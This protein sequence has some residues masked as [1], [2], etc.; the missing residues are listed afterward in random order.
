MTAASA[1]WVRGILGGVRGGV[2]GS[3]RH[4]GFGLTSSYRL[5]CKAARFAVSFQLRSAIKHWN[6]A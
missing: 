4:G 5:Q 2:A 1:G 6:L 3:R